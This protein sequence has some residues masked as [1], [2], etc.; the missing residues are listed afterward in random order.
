A[1]F[2]AVAS[3]SA[4]FDL[5]VSLAEQRL[6]DGTPGGISGVI[7][8]ASDLFDAGSVETL[9]GRLVR[10][11]AA[12]V[13]HPDRALGSLDILS[14]EERATILRGWN[15]T[16]RAL[17]QASLP[18][19][20]TAQAAARPDAIAVVFEEEALSYDEL[21]ARA[22]WLAHYLRGRGVGPEVMVGL[23]LEGSLELGVGL[24]PILKAGGGYLPLEPS[25]PRERLAFMLADAGAPI[26]LTRSSLSERLGSHRAE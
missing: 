19:Q 16:A 3:T 10:L 7:E 14:A 23:C 15:D 12:A 5:S 20:F 2:A 1:R 22:N 24:L 17:P 6:A 8:Y 9:G 13:A 26:V 11:I 21:E 4:K 18:E 25:Y